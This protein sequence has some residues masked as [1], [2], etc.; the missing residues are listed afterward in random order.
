MFKKILISFITVT[1]L[2]SFTNPVFARQSDSYPVYIVQEGDT[3]SLIAEKFGISLNDLLAANNIPNTNVLNIGDRINIPGF[4]GISG[5]LEIKTFGVGDTL[6]LF[7]QK[8]HVTPD[9]LATLNRITNPTALFAGSELIVP[10]QENQK[11][12]PAPAMNPDH[13]LLESAM[14]LGTDIWSIQLNNQ[15][16][17]LWGLLPGDGFFPPVGKDAQNILPSSPIKEITIDPLPLI[18][19]ATEVIHVKT[20]RPVTLNADL[21]SH[22]IDFF[23]NGENDYYALEGIDAFFS[24]T[25]LKSLTISSSDSNE[26]KVLISQPI[27][28]A[29]GKFTQEVVNGV[30]PSTIDPKVIEQENNILN[31]ITTTSPEKLWNG[32]FKSP[33]DEPCI[34]STFGNRRSY[35]EGAY[36]YYHTGVDFSVCKANNINIYA[37]APGIV[38]YTGLLPTKGNYTLIDH[39]WGVYSGY[40]HQSVFKVQVGDHVTAGQTIGLIG[41]TG[42]A[43]GPHLH[44]EVWVNHKLVDPLPWLKNS[45][46]N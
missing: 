30:D 28:L 32:P 14:I 44:F 23:K 17:Q 3:L 22:Q 19:G 1:M 10:V 18:Q 21:S 11:D 12:F 7:C 27:L 45:Y 15:M 6:N 4:P 38:V 46:P 20:T 43:L 37:V 9:Q 40:A 35:N 42:R 13:H 24:Q 33:V 41:Q 25:G 31:S 2:L 26:K 8:Y 5:V 39:G 36:L 16:Q 34:G 29:P